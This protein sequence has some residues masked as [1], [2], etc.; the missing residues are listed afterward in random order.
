MIKGAPL[1][2]PHSQIYLSSGPRKWVGVAILVKCDSPF[3]CTYDYSDPQG[4]FLGLWQG[5][6]VTFCAVYAPNV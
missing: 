2:F 1:S 6:E 4:H 5:Q 3:V